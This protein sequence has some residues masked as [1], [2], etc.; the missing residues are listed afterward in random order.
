MSLLLCPTRD[1][2]RDPGIMT[3][4][5]N[6]RLY[7]VMTMIAMLLYFYCYCPMLLLMTNANWA[8][9]I[10]KFCAESSSPTLKFCSQPKAVTSSLRGCGHVLYQRLCGESVQV[11]L[12]APWW[13]GWT[14]SKSQV[15]RCLAD[16]T[17]HVFQMHLPSFKVWRSC[18]V[19]VCFLWV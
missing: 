19:L 1:F 13:A 4:V 3:Q 8:P 10:T 12:A 2:W 16:S 7:V 6:E 15:N 18:N 5:F 14:R 17:I 11:I 9:M